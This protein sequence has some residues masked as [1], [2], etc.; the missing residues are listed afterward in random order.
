MGDI[1]PRSRNRTALDQFALIWADRP[2]FPPEQSLGQ[3]IEFANTI[4]EKRGRIGDA[5][6]RAVIDA[7]Y[8]PGQAAEIVAHVALNVFTNYFNNVAGTEIDFPKVTVS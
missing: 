1:N 8:T 4:V 5:D 6:F 3:A 2:A 7:G